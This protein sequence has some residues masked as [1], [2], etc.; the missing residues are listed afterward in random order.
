M[1]LFR[2]LFIFTNLF[3]HFYFIF[4]QI[5]DV[6][7]KSEVE[8]EN[9]PNPPTWAIIGDSGFQGLQNHCRALLPKKKKRNRELTHQDQE[10]NRKLARAR[11]IVENFYGRMARKFRIMML[12]IV[13]IKKNII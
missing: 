12:N 2:F 7:T 8:F 6:L 4:V 1:F 9:Y 5:A 3:V 13:M 11:V 10:W